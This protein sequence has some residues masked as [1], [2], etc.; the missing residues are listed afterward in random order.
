REVVLVVGHNVVWIVEQALGAV[1]EAHA[2][3]IGVRALAPAPL[4]MDDKVLNLEKTI[5][6]KIPVG[7]LLGVEAIRHGPLRRPAHSAASIS[8]SATG[9]SASASSASSKR[10][11]VAA[12]AVRLASSRSQS[13]IS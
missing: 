2:E 7:D 1:R 8:R 10:R 11:R 6:A 3:Q 4:G 13:A 12:M 9:A 5:Q